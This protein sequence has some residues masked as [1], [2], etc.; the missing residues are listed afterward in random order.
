MLRSRHLDGRPVPGPGPDAGFFGPSSEIWRVLRER[1]VLIGGMRALMMHAAHPLVA[2][3]TQTRL[4]ES[5]SWARHERTLRLTFTLVFGSRQEAVAAARHIN[6][7]HRSVRGVEHGTGLVYDARDPELLLWVHATLIS[8]FLLFERL[9]VGRLDDVRRQRFHE[10]GVRMAGLLGLPADRIPPR[11]RDLET[12]IDTTIGSDMLRLTPGGQRVLAVM[13]GKADGVDGY[14]SRMAGFLALHTLPRA[15]R[16]LYG[17]DHDHSDERK[18]RLLGEAMRASR[19]ALPSRTR[20]IGPA[21][22][23]YARMRGEAVLISDIPI[24]PRW[25]RR[26]PDAE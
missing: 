1:S 22:A 5:D 26:E 23:G 20:F 3:A 11:L 4:Y 24:L 8:S 9:T 7:A 10:D 6:L 12:W 19:V 17:I 25:R 18:L 15:L 13:Q 16:D 2:V 21:I 14:R